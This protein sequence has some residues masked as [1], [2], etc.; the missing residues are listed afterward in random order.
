M[1][2]YQT[3]VRVAFLLLIVSPVI[4][5][6]FTPIKDKTMAPMICDVLQYGA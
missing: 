6:R 4:A 5:Q 3:V 1:W 2:M